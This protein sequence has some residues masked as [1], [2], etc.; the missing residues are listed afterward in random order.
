MS[1]WRDDLI[2]V[3]GYDENFVGWGGEDS[4]IAVRLINNGT[5]KRFLKM[6][7]VC[8]HIYHK[9]ASREMHEKNSIIANNAISNKLIFAEKGL[10]QYL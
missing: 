3:N 6:G 4:D 2:R 8:H 7:G 1:F 5:R 9:E 10:N